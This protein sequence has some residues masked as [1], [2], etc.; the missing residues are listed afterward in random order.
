VN[1]YERRLPHWDA[2]GCSMFVTFRL[3][4]SLPENRVF[5]PARV[6]SGQAF[7][8]M[9]RLLDRATDGP[10]FLQ[11][12]EIAQIVVDAIRDGEGRFHRYQLHA[13]V[14]MPNHVHLLVTPN[15]TANHWLGPLKGFT[16]RIAFWENMLHS[17]RTRAMTDWSATEKSSSG[18]S[19][20]LR[21][22]QSR[23]DWLGRRTVSPGRVHLG[24]RRAEAQR[25]AGKPDPTL[26][27]VET[28][29]WTQFTFV[30]EGPRCPVRAL[31]I[32]SYFRR[33]EVG[34]RSFPQ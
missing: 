16:K 5:P 23:Q 10:V 3:S 19:G 8:A 31:E 22:I 17:G 4:G 2:V 20:T 1:R 27:L 7:V 34:F 25:Q 6:S 24:S 30:I 11:Q 26:L 9:D 18:S 21:T 32:Y 28:Q 14:V 12:Q 15:V 29:I 13:Y 33:P